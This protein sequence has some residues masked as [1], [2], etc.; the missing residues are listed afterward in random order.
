MLLAESSSAVAEAMVHINELDAIKTSLVSDLELVNTSAAAMSSEIAQLK[1]AG[2]VE[3]AN[4]LVAIGSLDSELDDVRSELT[5]VNLAK[6]ALTTA[7]AAKDATIAQLQQG[8]SAS[9]EVVRLREALKKAEKAVNLNAD[10]AEKEQAR[11]DA[12]F[13]QL[14]N[15][16][17]P[18]AAGGTFNRMLCVVNAAALATKSGKDYVWEHMEC[19]ALV[20]S[21]VE[22]M[23][24]VSSGAERVK[25]V[26]VMVVQVVGL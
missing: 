12:A 10:F 2:A 26:N 24:A 22:G 23:V 14:E 6:D 5:V 3:L 18:M 7:I 11:A 16:Q 8:G 13:V 9:G 21:M 20:R 19:E 1:S 15:L 4:A 25:T 17:N